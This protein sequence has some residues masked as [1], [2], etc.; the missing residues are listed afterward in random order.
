[1]KI[2]GIIDFNI[3]DFTKI[4]A[5]ET[6][7]KVITNDVYEN[8]AKYFKY[9]NY[10]KLE[11]NEM[12]F[13]N[14][15]YDVLKEDK[16]T[17]QDQKV[18]AVLTA[19]YF[20]GEL[21]IT[22]TEDFFVMK[23][24]EL[25]IPV[26]SHTEYSFNKVNYK[27]V[28]NRL[29][30]KRTIPYKFAYLNALA[31]NLGFK[32]F[33]IESMDVFKEVLQ[34]RM[35]VVDVISN[36]FVKPI[37]QL[38]SDDK[39]N[40]KEIQKLLK[41]LYKDFSYSQVESE[42]GVAF[43]FLSMVMFEANLLTVKKLY[44]EYIDDST[45]NYN[46]IYHI[47]LANFYTTH[48][49]L[50]AKKDFMI[51]IINRV[52]LLLQQQSLIDTNTQAGIDF[53]KNLRYNF[54]LDNSLKTMML[55]LKELNAI[56][57]IGFLIYM[58]G[59]VNNRIDPAVLMV[60]LGNRLIQL[61][62]FTTAQKVANNNL[63]N[64]FRDYYMS[65]LFPDSIKFYEIDIAE[66]L[67]SEHG[68]PNTK[69]SFYVLLKTVAEELVV[70]MNEEDASLIIRDLIEMYYKIYME[71]DVF[72]TIL[73]YASPTGIKSYVLG[74]FSVIFNASVYFTNLSNINFTQMYDEI[75]EKVKIFEILDTYS[76][77][78][79]QLQQLLYN[80]YFVIDEDGLFN[81]MVYPEI[82]HNFHTLNY[83]FK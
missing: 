32:P 60:N 66:R 65:H 45:N 72:N 26:L 82:D 30:I 37:I 29:H 57:T 51:D 59:K 33:E 43:V 55:L 27:D 13:S 23:N 83:T 68:K 73:D 61:S 6:S 58:F 19:L 4:K 48:P 47:V 62:S 81:L 70:F 35:E 28:I 3:E 71:K 64:D 15:L 80:M 14:F 7:N 20:D 38:L 77:K 24:M 1:M 46:D 78:E 34:R 44:S 75:S 50:Y 52:T 9:T 17:I 12:G 42:E 74:V 18:L 31:T 11:K 76:E 5:N 56:D 22:D 21:V 53:I 2:T 63:Q 39:E 67:T 16:N 40:D 25:Y 79:Y 54:K 10:K 49:E 69:D 8:I 36:E 41:K